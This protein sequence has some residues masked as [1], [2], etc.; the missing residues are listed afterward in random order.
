MDTAAMGFDLQQTIERLARTFET[1]PRD[2]AT[3]RRLL[4]AVEVAH[5]AGLPVELGATQNIVYDLTR[6]QAPRYDAES[7]AG[8]LIELLAASLKVRLPGAA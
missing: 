6:T 8:R 2:T 3:V 1:D 4:K 7:E 5:S